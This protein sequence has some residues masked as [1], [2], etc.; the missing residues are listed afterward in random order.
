MPPGSRQAIPMTATGVRDVLIIG[1]KD[2]ADRESAPH[3][4]LARTKPFPPHSN[5]ELRFGLP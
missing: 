3:Y 2:I 4:V 1:T 5:V